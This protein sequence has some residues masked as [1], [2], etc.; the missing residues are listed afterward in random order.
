MGKKRK[1]SSVARKMIVILVILGAITTL[2]CFLNIM[3]YDVLDGFNVSMKEK[4]NALSSAS[5]DDVA[6]LTEEANY[7]L[8]RIDVK[9]SGTYIFDYILLVVALI[10]TV[11]AIIVSLRLIVNP[12]KKVSKTL[13]NVVTSIKN[14]EGD[15]TER[16]AVKNNDEIGRMASGINDFIELLQNNMITMRQSA[17]SLQASMDLMTGKIDESNASVTNVSAST[18]ELAACMEE[19]AASVQEIS[20]SSQNVLE[21]VN[22]IND[23]AK[24]GVEVVSDLEE[25][26]TDTRATVMDNKNA[27]T[28]IITSIQDELEVAL[29]ESKSVGKIQELTEGIL[30]IAA[31]T[32]LLA[33]NASI[34]AA[35]AGEA[36]K[37]FAVVA[38]QIRELADSSQQAASGIQDI[39][40]LVINAV[41]KLVDNANKMIQFMKGNVVKDY[42]AFVDIMS[43]YQKD[44]I[45]LCDLIQGFA[46]EASA[47]AK[48]M[49]GMN[50][51]MSDIALT[52]DESANAVTTVATDASELVEAMA[53][54]KSETSAN[55]QLSEELIGVVKRFK[56]L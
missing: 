35:R 42:D 3:A 9:I 34:E 39:S 23:E 29:E 15:L 7:L 19:V 49:Q 24:H 16:V 56:K 55:K 52:I 31:Q 33:L 12:T 22:N 4:V 32:N 48:T 47:M 13:D 5:G 8:E 21:Q 36:G 17:D 45:E 51:G 14:N 43:Q 28:D 11:V 30:K 41:N 10:V 6:K 1:N 18:Q 37:G 53:E 44:T 54:I 26:V 20:Y 38:D 2:M 25:R 27:T 46:N 40:T 50:S